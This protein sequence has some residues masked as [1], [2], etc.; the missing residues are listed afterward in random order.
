[1][2]PGSSSYEGSSHISLNDESKSSR[3]ETN[4]T[5]VSVA[6]VS[7]NHDQAAMNS[8]SVGLK[9]IASPLS[10]SFDKTKRLDKKDRSMQNTMEI[11]EHNWTAVHYH[12]CVCIDTFWL[13]SYRK[14]SFLFKRDGN[15]WGMFFFV[16]FFY[17]WK[18]LAFE[19][20]PATSVLDGWWDVREVHG[21]MAS[22]G[23]QSKNPRTHV[24][25]VQ[26]R[27]THHKCQA[28]IFTK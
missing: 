6:L 21:E 15:C 2:S 11:D 10:S 9:R 25:I 26:N 14:I 22:T 24:K 3:W 18:P 20:L 4:L 5:S 8:S 16:F 1:M 23:S 28:I 13:H 7:C 19:T 17:Y 12:P 27:A